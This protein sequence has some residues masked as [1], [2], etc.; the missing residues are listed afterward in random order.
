MVKAKTRT[1]TDEAK[2]GGHRLQ[3]WC[4]GP[5]SRAALLPDPQIEVSFADLK[6]FDKT[7]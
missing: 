2:Q 5:L 6:D 4:D 3:F 1:L 7:A